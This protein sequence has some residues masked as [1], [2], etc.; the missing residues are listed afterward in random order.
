MSASR[1]RAFDGFRHHLRNKLAL[2]QLC[3]KNICANVRNLVTYFYWHGAGQGTAVNYL[4]EAANGTEGNFTDR[5]VAQL[6]QASADVA[7]W[8][9]A[10]MFLNKKLATAREV[11]QEE[12]D[13]KMLAQQERDHYI[14][15]RDEARTS[16]RQMRE[17]RDFLVNELQAATQKIKEQ[18]EELQNLYRRSRMSPR[19]RDRLGI[20][21]GKAQHVKV[22]LDR[23]CAEVGIIQDDIVYAQKEG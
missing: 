4:N 2:G 15:E 23:L 22:Q 19:A 14:Q 17:D 10:N 12:R 6:K 8:N 7:A 20:A 3:L 13:A 16:L 1:W 5:C 9:E 18:D 21:L 11:A